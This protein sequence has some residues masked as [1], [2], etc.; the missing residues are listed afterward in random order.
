M[1]SFRSGKLS[2]TSARQMKCVAVSPLTS[3]FDVDL[4]AWVL[5][6]CLIRPHQPQTKHHS[7]LLERLLI[8][9]LHLQE[10]G[11]GVDYWADFL[12][13]QSEGPV[14]WRREIEEGIKHCAKVVCIVDEAWLTSFNCLQVRAC[15]ACTFGKFKSRTQLGC[16]E[17]ACCSSEI[18]LLTIYNVLQISPV[19][20][21]RPLLYI[22]LLTHQQQQQVMT[23]SASRLSALP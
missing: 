20:G 13:L 18:Q 7:Y 11:A 6:V 22:P 21:Y 5:S 4:R 19:I 10:G 16:T 9:S 1:I 8:A 23:W 15:Y 12:D 17:A 3:G 2:P 14:Q